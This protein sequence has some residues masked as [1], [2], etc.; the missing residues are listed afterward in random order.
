M[1]TAHMSPRPEESNHFHRA[2]FYWISYNMIWEGNV[3]LGW[4]LAEKRWSTVWLDRMLQALL[5]WHGTYNCCHCQWF[6]NTW[7]GSWT[8]MKWTYHR[9]FTLTGNP[10][11]MGWW[12]G[13]LCQQSAAHPVTPPQSLCLQSQLGITQSVIQKTDTYCDMQTHCRVAGVNRWQYNSR[14]QGTALWTRF[15]GNK[16]TH[17]NGR[18]IFCAVRARAI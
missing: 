18:N 13:I 8:V 5:A 12:C 3:T 15:P 9:L 11:C 14:W 1:R 2:V 7:A 4:H 10:W 16:R 17:N 6:S